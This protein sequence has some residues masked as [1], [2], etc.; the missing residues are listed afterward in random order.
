MK[1]STTYWE[2]L[3]KKIKHPKETKNKRPD[4]S[5]IEVNFLSAYLDTTTQILDIGSGTGLIINKLIE[6][7]GHITAVEKFRGFTKHIVD[8]PNMLVINADL[9]GFFMRKSFDVILC[10]GVAQC[11]PKQTMTSI[12]EDMFQMLKPGGK[13][14]LR[15]H[16]G[17]QE[18]VLVNGYSEELQTD[19]FAEYRQKD[20]EISLL[21]SIGFTDIEVHDILPDTINVWE[22]TRHFYFVC[23][24]SA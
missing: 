9:E 22:N 10:T 1:D 5:D 18:D 23:H 14:L 6:K 21:E 8:H 4:T 20:K 11:F 17:L 19:Y 15:M 3:S 7:V 16:C 13:M 12:Y 2:S 24:K